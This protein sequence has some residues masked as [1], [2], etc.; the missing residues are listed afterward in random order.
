MRRLVCVVPLSLA[1]ST[2]AVAQNYNFDNKAQFA[3]YK[4]YKW[5]NLQTQQQLDELTSG[6]L[7]GTLETELAKKGLTKSQSDDA[8]L[9]IGYVIAGPNSNQRSY[10]V[11]TAYGPTIGGNAN[12]A[13]A[14]TTVHSGR[15]ILAMFDAKS[16]NLVWQAMVPDAIDAEAKPDKKQKHMTKA[17]EKLLKNYPPPHKS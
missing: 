7:V 5:V 13:A 4:T 1:L 2:C 14:I 12:A 17:V 9:Y 15:V 16:K 6:Q 8:D 3:A 11:G 10:D